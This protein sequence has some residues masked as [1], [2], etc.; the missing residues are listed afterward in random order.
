MR[1]IPAATPLL[2][3]FLAAATAAS[4]QDG[5]TG[6]WIVT[7]R[8]AG[9]AFT[10]SCDFQ[11]A[12]QALT[13]VCADTA[14]SDAKV[15]AG[16]RHVLTRGHADGDTVTWTYGSSFLFSHFDV[17]YSGV[18]NGDRMAGQITVQD[19]T[20]AFTAQRAAP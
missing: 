11:Q 3:A 12:G 18:L 10:L 13:G 16:R 6:H 19:R 15:K 17:D 1:R 5:A 20:G 8:V 2:L 9:F 7:G 4:A 14:T